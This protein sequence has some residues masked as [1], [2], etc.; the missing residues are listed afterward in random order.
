MASG[1]YD[2]GVADINALIKFRDANPKAPVKA[3]FMVYNRP[4]F[5]V[6]GRKSRGIVAPKDLEGKK[7][8]APAASLPMRNGRFSSRSTAS[9]PPR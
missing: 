2:M 7:L 1:N 9:T 3:V 4:A 6:I 8:G 5:A